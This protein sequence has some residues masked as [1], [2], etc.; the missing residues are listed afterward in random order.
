MWCK[1][2]C[3][4]VNISS[5]AMKTAEKHFP[6]LEEPNLLFRLISSHL[7]SSRDRFLPCY[8]PCKKQYY[9]AVMLLWY[10]LWYLHITH[11]H[12]KE[13][14]YIYI[15]R[16]CERH[17]FFFLKS[18]FTY[19]FVNEHMCTSWSIFISALWDFTA[20][21]LPSVS[22]LLPWK[23]GENMRG[24]HGKWIYISQL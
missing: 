20:N 2:L 12:F 21:R 14:H 4:Q 9:S 1:Q 23:P 17:F 11:R 6:P 16:T 10:I 3:C 19:K 8:W 13:N 22:L 5:S 7:V 24:V 18:N 15:T